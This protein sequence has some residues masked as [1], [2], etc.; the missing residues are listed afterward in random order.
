MQILLDKLKLISGRKVLDIATGRGNFIYYLKDGFKDFESITGID[1]IEEEKL[2]KIS[3]S[4]PDSRIHFQ[5]MNAS[6]LDF[7]DESFDTVSLSNSLHHLVDMDS[8]LK[9]M[10]RVVKPGGTIILNEMI[11][12]NQSPSQMTYVLMHHWW[13]KIDMAMGKLHY[14]TFP[15]Q[16][17]LDIVKGMNLRSF[18]VLEFNDP[19]DPMD[20]ESLE[21]ISKIID[22]YIERAK[23]IDN[24]EALKQ[25]GE[26]IRKRLFE[27]GVNGATQVIII[28]NR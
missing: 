24:F 28:G 23:A 25:E 9:E 21:G 5:H 3:E 14:E 2:K 17:V 6:N 20:K 8:V 19:D 26:E 1:Y 13:A 27:V 12:D 15:K 4:F 11:C 7:S 18:E 10:L 22:E 16:K